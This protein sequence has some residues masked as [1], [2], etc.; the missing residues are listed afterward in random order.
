MKYTSINIQG[1]LISE[2]ILQKI[3]D[4]EA[5]GQLA[6][7][8]GFDSGTNLRSE[9]EYAWSKI[10]L[11]WKY[12]FER[13][14]KLPSSDPYGTTLSRKW[15]TSFFST[16]GFDLTLQ[17]A[18]LQGDNQQYYNISHTC[19]NL[20][21]LPVHIVGFFDPSHPEKNTLDIKSSGGTSRL[22]PHATIQEYLNVTEYLY[23]MAT[24]GLVL[25]LIRDSGR[26][27]RM[28]YIEFDLR[29]LLEEDKYSEFTLLYRLL[30]ASRFPKT[31]QEEEP[32]F[33]ERYYQDSIESGN[34]IRDG[35]SDAVKESLVALGNGLL[36]HPDNDEL[37][38]KISH[39]RPDAREF[40]H[41]LLRLIYR[42]LFLMVTE[43]RD[44]IFPETEDENKEPDLDD[45]LNGIKRP[46]RKQKEIYYKYYSVTRL[47]RL[48]QK[49]YLLENQY[50]DLWQ[51]LIQ[52]FALFEPGGAGKKLGIQALGGELFSHSAMPDISSARVD[53]RVLL[54]CIKSLNE[55]ED[56]KHNLSFINYRALDVEEL[57]SVYEGLLE[58][59]P[60]F[61]WENGRPK[62]TFRKGSERS[63]SGSHYTPEDLVKP[64]IQHSLEYLIEERVTDFYKGRSKE[65]EIKRK[66][67]DLKVCDVACGSGHILLSAAR[68]IALEVARFETG[69]Q[70][71][72]PASF[73]HSLKEV[74]KNCIYGVDK[75]PLAV[76][77]CKVALWL[78]SHNPGEPLS[79]L[80]HKIKCGDAI[81]GLAHREELQNGIANEAFKRLPGDNKEIASAFL[82]K[83][84][85]ERTVREKSRQAVQLTTETDHKLM[86]QVR[87]LNRLIENFSSLPE[88]TPEEIEK[89]EKAYR[90]L[91]NSDALRRLKIMADL[92]I[93][94]FF[95]PKTEANKDLLLTDSQYFRYLRGE[96]R[97]PVAIEMKAIETGVNYRF[98]HW[99]LEFPEVFQNGGFDCILGNP[100]FLGGQKISGNFGENYLEFLKQEYSPI[101]AV[102]L[103]TY[104]FRRIFNIITIRGF[105]SLISTN[106]IAQGRAREGGLDFIIQ[107][108]GAINHAVKSMKW[109]GKAAV[110]VSLITVTKQLWKR[111]YIL[112]GKEVK[113]ISSYLD[114]TFKIGK[115]FTLKQNESKSF[116][117]TIVH[118]RGFILKSNEVDDLISRNSR[119]G[120]VLFPYLDGDDLNNDPEQKPGRWVINFKNWPLR[121]Y[122]VD[123]W[124]NLEKEIQN[125]VND[126]LYKNKI[127]PLA[128][129]DYDKPV[130]SDYFDCLQ[131]IEE[132]VKQERL[133]MKG[134]RGAEYWWQFLRTRNELYQTIHNKD[135]VLVINRHTKYIH[136]GFISPYLVYSDATVVLVLNNYYEFGIFS[137]NIHTEWS[138]KNSGTMGSSTL[139]Y[140]PTDCFE[141]FP[142]PQLSA[143]SDKNDL[144]KY[145]FLYHE[146]RKKLMVSLQLGLTS[147]YN[148]FNS[149]D[150]SD[151][152]VSHDTSKIDKEKN[153]KEFIEEIT[154]L[155]NHHQK[156]ND[157]CNFEDLVKG[158]SKL[159]ELQVKMD[160]AVLE[161]YGWKDMIHD[162]YPKVKNANGEYSGRLH[163]FYEVD[164]LPEN[165]RVRFTI[166]PDARKEV[167]KRLLELNH[168]IHEEEVKA[169]LWDKKKTKKKK[170]ESSDSNGDQVN[171]PEAGY[172]GL[173]G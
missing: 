115:P 155:R 107:N 8:F 93:M 94:P 17:K 35:L 169:G 101:G 23:A 79:F 96:I 149:R 30:H 83:N 119:N 132:R 24:N 61:E 21:G 102:D 147:L 55:F 69:E 76:E 160:K 103:V 78:E 64:L 170:A 142:F 144:E 98:F 87:K 39:N 91:I 121:R 124:E 29:R 9:I 38:E 158:I 172:G 75:N 145:G 154:S 3:E 65:E 157:N 148:L 77:L 49:R 41:Q 37:R 27:V 109:P 47:R 128:P 97:I 168:K 15:M 5:P 10:K 159:R 164:Y 58:L 62:F 129:P 173:F 31:R 162:N 116:Q 167:L 122:T 161:A 51:S 90:I 84:R 88:N 4:S 86:E 42:L 166:H 130:A 138:W 110:D 80:D 16:L 120:D 126:N 135:K 85:Q 125:T 36:E 7:D 19:D 163:D 82:K 152:I 117:G 112:S 18:S 67:L 99:F 45:L 81:V 14:E 140:S 33:I 111:K 11:D 171:E 104:F 53:N 131:I 95:I 28:T 113:T 43:E 133:K 13:I 89:K 118:G 60:L 48:S 127:T 52:T 123:E 151:S 150:L 56:E 6:K 46:T 32:C 20:D 66:L 2:E 100:P 71:P 40:Y 141:T 114:D 153:E 59:E 106:T 12:F 146:Y 34:R 57:G 137:S 134:D 63:K 73:R 70:Q 44:L 25:R 22:S 68:R 26:L 105:Q 139:R 143:N 1:N 165:D 156:I 72:N 92:Q 50:T 108:G 136:A 54:K 74:I